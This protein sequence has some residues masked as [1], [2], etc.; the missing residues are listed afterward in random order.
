V[1]AYEGGWC[2]CC[3]CCCFRFPS[4]EEFDGEWDLVLMD[5]LLPLLFL[6]LSLEEESCE[7]EAVWDGIG[8]EEE[9]REEPE[10]F[11]LCGWWLVKVEGAGGTGPVGTGGIVG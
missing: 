9:E 6:F 1:E 2:C 11:I 7:Y 10:R 3:R 5:E 8:R 4:E